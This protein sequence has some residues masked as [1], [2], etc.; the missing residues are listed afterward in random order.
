MDMHD[1]APTIAFL[2][3]FSVPL[4]AILTKHQQKMA[5]ILRRP[6]DELPAYNRESM[7]LKQM[8]RDQILAVEQLRG[9]VR[10]LKELVA[11][12]SVAT[13]AAS[14]VALPPAPLL[15]ERV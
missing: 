12:Q 5:M 14:R 6:V 15:Q 7:E 13:A 10:E 11:A 9:E 1:F 2:A 3:I 8:V 4:I